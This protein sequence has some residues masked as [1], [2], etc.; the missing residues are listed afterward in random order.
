MTTSS[1][2]F[3]I[4]HTTELDAPP[5]DVWAVVADYRCDPQWRAGVISMTPSPVGPV[6]PGTTTSE[7]LRLGGKVWHND[8]EVTSVDPGRR[9]AWRTTRG[10]RARGARAV[11][12]IGNGRSRV[13]LE[14]TVT[15]KGVERV[16]APVLRR[17]LDRNLAG[18]L[19]RLRSV[20]EAAATPT[21]PAPRV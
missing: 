11:E 20:V 13:E 5:E 18:D 4:I 12:P 10:A 9:F 8:G 15:P 1:N 16:M 21:A 3:T 19:D 7:E 2:S 17:M 14:L 6:S